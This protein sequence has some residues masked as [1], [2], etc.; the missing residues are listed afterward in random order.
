[1]AETDCIDEVIFT[2]G[3]AP[4]FTDVWHGIEYGWADH[5]YQGTTL[6]KYVFT[7]TNAE[8]WNA[9]YEKQAEFMSEIIE[10]VYFQQA[11]DIS[12]NLY[13]VAVLA[14]EQ[15]QRLDLQKRL[16][17]SS[18]TEFTRNL[19]VSLEQLPD[20]VPVGRVPLSRPAGDLPQPADVWTNA[21]ERDGFGF[22]LRE[23][24]SAALERYLETGLSP[25]VKK[26]LKR[27]NAAQQSIQSIRE[28]RIP[29]NFR[30]HY[31][32]KDW[33]I[34][35]VSANVLYGPNG[36]GKTS[37][38]SAIEAALTGE[39]SCGGRQEQFA[40]DGGLELRLNTDQGELAVRPARDNAEKK[41]RE[42]RWYLNRE[43]NRPKRQL[44]E[45]FHRF[46][47][48][49]SEE[50]FLFS[51]K[52]QDYRDIFT[53]ILYGPNTDELWRNRSRYL[54]EC[55]KCA[56][57]LKE[58][59]AMLQNENNQLIQLP[60][61]D[62]F[63]LTVLLTSSGLAIPSDAPLDKIL[64]TAQTVLTECQKFQDIQAVLSKE[65]T[66]QEL[67][68]RRKAW[69]DEK[70]QRDI[71]K[72]KYQ[73]ILEQKEHWQ[74]EKTALEGQQRRL[75]EQN[76]AL[77]ALTPAKLSVQH[78]AELNAYHATRAEKTE[79]QCQRFNLELLL[80]DYGAALKNPPDVSLEEG[81]QRLK[82]LTLHLSNLKR[83]QHD[84]EEKIQQ[85]ELMASQRSK[86]MALLRSS[87]LEFY[88]WDSDLDTCPLCGT[89]G[90]TKSVLLAHMEQDQ[91]QQQTALV[92]LNQKLIQVRSDLAAAEEELID[93][94]E[95]RKQAQA[96][97]RASKEILAKFP[98]LTTPKD[99]FAFEDTLQNRL[100]ECTRLVSRRKA[101]LQRLCGTRFDVDE[102][103]PVEES[104]ASLM[105][106]LSSRGTEFRCDLSDRELLQMVSDCQS[107]LKE[108]IDANR[109]A[110]LAVQNNLEDDSSGFVLKQYWAA[111]DQASKLEKELSE[112]ERRKTFWEKV[113]FVLKEP[114]L[115]AASLKALCV[116]ICDTVKSIMEYDDYT[117]RQ[118]QCC[119]Q[120]Q[121]IEKK[122][123]R[124]DSL[125]RALEKLTPPRVYAE[126]FIQQNIQQVSQIFSS[127]HQPQEFYKL[128]IDP[129]EGLVGYRGEEIIPVSQMSTGQRTAL[130]LSV[131]FQM[132]LTADYTPA[133][134]LLDEPVANIDDL[135]I[136]ALIDFL[137]E[138]VITHHRQIIVTTA[139][140]NVAKLFRRKFS[141]LSEN[142]QELSFYREQELQL[143]IVKRSYS[144]QQ[145]VKSEAL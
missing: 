69:E 31:Y 88:E 80:S 8:Q 111:S 43:N 89:Q 98:N 82:D 126:R 131:F 130:V 58:R 65:Q 33:K 145:I 3:L 102:L 136:L 108:E 72:E 13:W 45:V 7:F 17:F 118:N 11:S 24:E 86:T 68:E 133:F 122:Q 117:K 91:S 109:R 74:E 120:I 32:P 141:F 79:V 112:L 115:S 52:R 96:F 27:K 139:N 42:Q 54:E 47:Y 110:L 23:Y 2:S 121:E 132:N 41:Q 116:N 100:E 70:A 119:R 142:F 20:R 77:E 26:P 99:V 53:K 35:L 6:A 104:R 48:F 125:Q 10:P 92:S 85:E 51:T 138:F 103:M 21:L 56:S 140:Q 105:V 16:T 127:L 29:R 37:V 67:S 57:N 4:D 93:S 46:N 84:L 94:K 113:Q 97:D 107:G 12:W 143:R 63:A 81:E 137:R 36:T 106:F 134:L 28:V 95:R 39:M 22:C 73:R 61:A 66:E 135:N 90:I 129:D 60:P 25:K 75:K 14:E 83:E 1:M 5:S 44:N 9:L 62:R 124:C 114:D 101:E 123:E 87:G 50:A 15:L 19:V 71:F 76:A 18:N 78:Q 49:S 38:L 30:P 55:K 59:L 64:E 34:P 144:Q 40:P 128:E